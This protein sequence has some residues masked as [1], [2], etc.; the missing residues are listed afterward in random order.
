[1]DIHLQTILDN[2]RS[3]KQ[4][5]LNNLGCEG[6]FSYEPTPLLIAGFYLLLAAIQNTMY[7]ARK[8]LVVLL[9]IY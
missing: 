5:N 2:S 4:T 3:Y 6:F 1:M 9:G 8:R 7:Q